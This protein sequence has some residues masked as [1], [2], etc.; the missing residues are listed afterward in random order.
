MV[1]EVRIE[2]RV[3][4]GQLESRLKEY[5]L[6]KQVEEVEAKCVLKSYVSAVEERLRRKDEDNEKRFLKME[7]E[8]YDREEVDQLLE[9]QASVIASLYLSVDDFQLF[10]EQVHQYQ[11]QLKANL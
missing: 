7:D 6:R 9:E 4:H 3:T 11:G 10:E 8:H 2:D 5:A 1:Q